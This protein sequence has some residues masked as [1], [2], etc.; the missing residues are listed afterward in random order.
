MLTPLNTRRRYPAFLVTQTCIFP[1]FEMVARYDSGEAFKYFERA[2]DV[3]PFMD[4][5][6]YRLIAP[7]TWRKS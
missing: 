7:D 5:H 1:R 4:R 6:G 3:V 2:D